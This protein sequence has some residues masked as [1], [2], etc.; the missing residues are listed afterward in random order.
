MKMKNEIS[1]NNHEQ[2]GK[3]QSPMKRHT[4]RDVEKKRRRGEVTLFV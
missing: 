2:K 1:I 4:D 3:Q